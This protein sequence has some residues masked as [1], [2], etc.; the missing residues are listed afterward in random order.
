MTQ[1][2]L[3]EAEQDAVTFPEELRFVMDLD[4]LKE[5]ERKNPLSVGERRERVAEHSWHLAT[6]AIL[7]HD[8][9]DENVDIAHASM[10]AVVHDIVE[11]FV[12]DTFAFGEDV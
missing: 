7:L 10:L 4:A 11:L 9:A 3:L 12:G 8:F 1:K 2:Q 5:V 6:A